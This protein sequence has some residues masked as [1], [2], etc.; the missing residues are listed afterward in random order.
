[1]ATTILFLKSKERQNSVC[2][3]FGNIPNVPSGS[4]KSLIKNIACPSTDLRHT[5]KN[6]IFTRMKPIDDQGRK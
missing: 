3:E 5:K 4:P 1:M 2:S 6:F